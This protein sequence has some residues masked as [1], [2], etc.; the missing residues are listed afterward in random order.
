VTTIRYC[1]H[2]GKALTWQTW[3][4]GFS[5]ETGQP[6]R[7]GAWRCPD[8]TSTATHTFLATYQL[9]GKSWRRYG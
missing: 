7:Y 2:C 4:Y 1:T 3:E 8:Y 6:E 5:G 9:R